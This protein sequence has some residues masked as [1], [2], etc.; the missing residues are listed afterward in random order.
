[1]SE[2]GESA[3]DD[4]LLRMAQAAGVGDRRADDPRPH[5]CFVPTA[6]GDSSDY[7]ERF[8]AAFAGRAHT[9]VLSLF[10][11]SPWDYRAP[12]HALRHG[13]RLCR[14][15]FD[16]EPPQ[17]VASAR[18]RRDSW[19]QRPTARSSPGSVQEQTAGS[20]P[21]R[22]IHSVL[23]PL[24]TVSGSSPE[25]SAR[26]STANPVGWRSFDAWIET[27]RLPRARDRHRRSCSGRLHLRAQ[28]PV[29]QH[30]CRHHHNLGD[31][32]GPRCRS[33]RH[34]SGSK[35]DDVREMNDDEIRRSS[36]AA[37][38][39]E[40]REA[41]P[42]SSSS[43]LSSSSTG[44]I[45]LIGPG[46]ILGVFVA[47]FFAACLVA[48]IMELVGRDTRRG[49]VLGIIGA[50]TLD[51]CRCGL[52]VALTV[53]G[54]IIDAPGRSQALATITAAV[55][56]VFFGGGAVLLITRAPGDIS[57]GRTNDRIGPGGL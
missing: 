27:G 38:R 37:Y 2:T 40:R 51:A 18:S 46:L 6:S 56:V 33:L 34:V 15:R 57:R 30:R 5:V 16:G 10:G 42:P 3:I 1:M 25:A 12:G 45:L 47:I 14:R 44:L 36:L 13:P 20:P 55:G 49:L 31:G 29:R 7:I 23:A 4:A 8:E 19:Q 9:H 11:Q 35:A 53:V 24:M 43:R 28:L 26:T 17:P 22:P 32:G 39:K 52:L 21:P 50:L 54:V 48:G 41:V